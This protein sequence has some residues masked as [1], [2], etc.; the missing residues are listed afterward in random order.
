MKKKSPWILLLLGIVALGFLGLVFV[1]V[2]VVG[3]TFPRTD[4][5]PTGKPS[6][7]FEAHSANEPKNDSAALALA[8]IHCLPAPK[9]VFRA[10]QAGLD[11]SMMLVFEIPRQDLDAFWEK[12]PFVDDERKVFPS[13][14][15]RSAGP[16]LPDGD[17]P[18]WRKWKAV[19]NGI[20][21]TASLPDGK[22]VR[23]FVDLE[24]REGMC[25]GYLFWHET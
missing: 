10:Y 7:G 23:I 12:T 9:V 8:G 18:E 3:A 5:P 11:D 4:S 13:P 6:F 1:L 24:D 16:M 14:G 19:K 17:A 20:I 15:R 22:F 25:R 21:S 2:F